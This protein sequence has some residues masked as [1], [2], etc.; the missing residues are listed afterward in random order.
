MSCPTKSKGFA[1]LEAVIDAA[2]GRDA[3]LPAAAV[4][5]RRTA[6]G[7]AGETAAAGEVVEPSAPI[8]DAVVSAAAIAD[9]GADVG[10]AVGTGCRAAGA[11]AARGPSV[12]PVFTAPDAIAAAGR[13]AVD[14]PTLAPRV[15]EEAGLSDRAE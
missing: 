11:I 4:G 3:I 10:A 9:G 13:A 12:M 8:V 15:S 1:V 6:A 5:T 2:A 7:G 14:F